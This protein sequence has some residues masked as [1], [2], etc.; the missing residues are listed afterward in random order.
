MLLLGVTIMSDQIATG[1]SRTHRVFLNVF[2]VFAKWLLIGIAVAAIGATLAAAF[3]VIPWLDLHT[4][5]ADGALRPIG[6]VVQIVGSI[7][8][9][10]LLAYLPGVSRVLE[11]ENSHRKFSMS[12]DDVARA[13][14]ISHSADRQSN[15][16]LSSEFDSMRARMEQLRDHPD[17]AMLE[18]ELL[19]L[20]AQMSH[21]TRDL[22]Q[23]YSEQKVRRAKAFLEERQHELDSYQEKVALALT[24]TEELKRWQQDIEATE[25]ET[26]RQIDRLEQDLKEIL[27][28]LGYEL[29]DDVLEPQTLRSD[30]ANV[31]PM[32]GA[33]VLS[34]P[35]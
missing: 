7:F 4:A 9:L 27:P 13:Y 34:K 1:A 30:D 25:R 17:L 19:E 11:L 3:G 6:P 15:F 29:D 5:D 8:L 24:L 35:D 23:V 32:S 16:A 33:P 12:V 31:V 18:P 14:Q 28:S 20:A 26:N 21:N 2:Q 10:A 22:A